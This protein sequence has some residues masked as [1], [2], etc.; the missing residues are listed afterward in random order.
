MPLT[1]LQDAL[2]S[3]QARGLASQLPRPEV[4]L[5]RWACRLHMP[6]AFWPT[7]LRVKTPLSQLQGPTMLLQRGGC[8]PHT[9]A[10]RPA[11]WPCQT[12]M[13]CTSCTA[14]PLR[15]AVEAS[16]AQCCP[17][18]RAAAL[19]GPLGG[20]DAFTRDGLS[21]SVAQLD[22]V[23]SEVSCCFHV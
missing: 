19:P 4:L 6:T 16:C 3:S 23:F 7:L 11:Q 13:L 15:H 22:K 20:I 5:Q 10:V 12:A 1:G 8:Q 2:R 14:S 21:T 18:C 17:V 9:R